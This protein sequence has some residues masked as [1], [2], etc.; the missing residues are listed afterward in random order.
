M[1]HQFNTHRAL[2]LFGDRVSE[3][4]LTGESPLPLSFGSGLS[5]VERCAN[6]AGIVIV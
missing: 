3:S 1:S 4:D 5:I 2:M 6:K